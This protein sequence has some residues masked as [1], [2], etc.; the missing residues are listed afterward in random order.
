M[1]NESDELLT[2]FHQI[3]WNAEDL[4]LRNVHN[5]EIPIC[6]ILTELTSTDCLNLIVSITLYL[7]IIKITVNNIYII[8]YVYKIHIFKI[9]I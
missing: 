6:S 1:Y 7:L 2:H 8:I 3:C 9:K 5:I 4:A